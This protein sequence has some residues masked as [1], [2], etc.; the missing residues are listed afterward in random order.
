MT[1]KNTV[2]VLHSQHKTETA[3]FT[4]NADQIITAV[5]GID[6]F[7]PGGQL[8]AFAVDP[9]N[10][11]YEL[12]ARLALHGNTHLAVDL[13]AVTEVDGERTALLAPVKS[14]SGSAEVTD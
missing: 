14:V 2:F 12:S 1:S 13:Y 5:T 11:E 4:V 3:S 9:F 7:R 6:G 10:S 8:I